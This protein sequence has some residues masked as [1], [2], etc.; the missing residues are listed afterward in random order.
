[1]K[2]ALIALLLLVGAAATMA[3]MAFAQD[4]GIMKPSYNLLRS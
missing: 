3:N 2:K 1:M 4:E